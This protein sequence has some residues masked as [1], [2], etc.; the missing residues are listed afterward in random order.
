MHPF[1]SPR[2]RALGRPKGLAILRAHFGFAYIESG[3]RSA[4]SLPN[5]YQN[6]WERL[7]APHM[8]RSL[9]CD[10][11]DGRLKKSLTFKE[12]HTLEVE[13]I[14]ASYTPRDRK[15]YQISSEFH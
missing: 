14:S 12:G 9:S 2:G 15:N 11:H 8:E 4:S 1:C 5:P 10:G 7:E 3:K 13:P 6:F